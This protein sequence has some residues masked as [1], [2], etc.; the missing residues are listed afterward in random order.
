M[1]FLPPGKDLHQLVI[2]EHERNSPVRSLAHQH[3]I[4]VILCQ[5]A[6]V[7]KYLQDKDIV[8]RDF[9]PANILYNP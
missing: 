4:S 7:I 9:T 8:H 5:Q 3:H 6:Q 2:T 1:Y